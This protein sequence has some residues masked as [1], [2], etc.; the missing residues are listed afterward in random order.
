M[1]RSEEVT[2]Y[3]NNVSIFLLDITQSQLDTWAETSFKT[4][5]L[6]LFCME[7]R[8]MSDA[9]V[10]CLRHKLRSPTVTSSAMLMALPEKRS[11]F[12]LIGSV[13]IKT[14]SLQK[15]L[16]FHTDFYFRNLL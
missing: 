7:K 6:D 14:V 9:V 12:L 1:G 3:L 16:K 5:K 15:S 8:K 4:S 11:R 13:K 2:K 10:K